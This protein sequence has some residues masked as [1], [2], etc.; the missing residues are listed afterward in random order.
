MDSFLN[1]RSIP[2]KHPSI[3]TQIMASTSVLVPD[4]GDF[5][6]IFFTINET[7]TQWCPSAVRF[8]KCPATTLSR[9]IST[10]KYSLNLVSD[11]T[12]RNSKLIYPMDPVPNCFR[13]QVSP[14]EHNGDGIN[15]RRTTQTTSRSLLLLYKTPTHIWYP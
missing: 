3:V 2:F 10:D 14:R 4:Q 15:M 8:T 11:L 7:K 13:V 6:D 5:I 9:Y 12:V 1:N